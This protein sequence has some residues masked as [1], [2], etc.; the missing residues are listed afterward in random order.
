ML[1]SKVP[2]D[3]T[4]TR[5]LPRRSVRRAAG[6]GAAIAL[7]SLIGFPAAAAPQE[8]VLYA[9]HGGASSFP[10]AGL[11]IDGNGALY[12]TT[13]GTTSGS[14]TVFMLA[15]PGPG[16]TGW[17]E[18]TLHTFRGGDDGS[19]PLAGLIMDASGALYG[20]TYDGGNGPCNPNNGCGTVFTLIRPASG[21]PRWTEKVLYRFKGGT[22]G[23]NPAA[24]LI[25]D[26]SGALYGTTSGGNSGVGCHSGC[27]TVY[28]LTPPAAGKTRWTERVLHAFASGADGA[29][30]F[31]AGVI[32][33]ASGALYGTTAAGG[34]AECLGIGC[35]TVFKLTPPATGETRWTERVL[36]RFDEGSSGRAPYA[37]LIM[38]ASGVLYGTTSEGG[39][40]RACHPTGCGTVF[41]LSPPESGETRWTETV[42]YAFT[43]GDGAN[44]AAGL[45]MDASGALYGTTSNGGGGDY[46]TVFKLVPPSSGETLWTETVL[47]S[48]TGAT[49]GVSPYAGLIMDA[50]GALY[51]T[52]LYGGGGCHC[53]T[54]FRVVP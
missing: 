24:G 15:P 39:G 19:A 21:E 42:L 33:D 26:A 4:A 27:G 9:F 3:H 43:G 1:H 30:P 29:A 10:Y 38:D 51:G 12:G 44:P 48:F 40:N 52:T 31:G 8:T 35:G 45:I 28:K 46:G 14:G 7:T 16:K 53:G 20:T 22:D 32:M 2:S 6:L 50:S 18:T 11:V 47:F 49:D 17:S 37:G 25:M 41:T 36:Y 23:A 13:T 5:A 34:S 54:V